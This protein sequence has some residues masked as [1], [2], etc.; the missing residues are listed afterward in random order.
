MR[1]VGVSEPLGAALRVET[2]ASSSRASSG[3]PVSEHQ[4]E[5]AC[6]QARKRGG[7]PTVPGADTV[8]TGV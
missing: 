4:V 2:V 1:A 6:G 5:F 8:G 7:I 3:R